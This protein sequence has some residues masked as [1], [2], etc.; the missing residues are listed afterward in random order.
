MNNVVRRFV[1]IAVA[2]AA[3][4]GIAQPASATC[5]TWCTMSRVSAANALDFAFVA[6][7]KYYA[8]VVA[9]SVKLYAS[10]S[11]AV[12]LTVP[13]PAGNSFRGIKVS[14]N[15]KYLFA[16]TAKTVTRIDL[17]AL[18]YVDATPTSF[19]T[20]WDGVPGTIWDPEVPGGIYGIAPVADGSAYFAITN[21]EYYSA[22]HKVAVGTKAVEYEEVSDY[23]GPGSHS[24]FATVLASGKVLQLSV[25]A[26]FE[27]AD[28]V[29]WDV[30]TDA[31]SNCFDVLGYSYTQP[32][33]SQIGYLV[34]D[35]GTRLRAF[36][37][38]NVI[39]NSGCDGAASAIDVNLHYA[40]GSAYVSGS[41]LVKMADGNF[42]TN[43]FNSLVQT[44]VQYLSPI[45]RINSSTGVIT[46]VANTTYV[47]SELARDGLGTVM[48]S[49]GQGGVQGISVGNPIAT[50]TRVAITRT[51]SG[52]FALKWNLV[53]LKPGA[54][55]RDY[56][57][58]F[59]R[60]S[61]NATSTVNDGV[62]ATR[63]ATVRTTVAGKY[64][65][66]AVYTNGSVSAWS[67]AVIAT[68]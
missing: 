67:A 35:S 14:G 63:S 37:P 33:A 64:Q 36:N 51:S 56:Q 24:V 26:S 47:T 38:S 28:S 46:K 1:A 16:H 68:P 2:V 27:Y 52:V 50:P 7:D 11:Q 23:W 48:V 13:A 42:Y 15:G 57:I 10:D 65:V 59:K 8:I 45:V 30:A 41:G 31:D 4:M 19:S 18:T 43:D 20:L 5:V 39:S 22:V 62:S 21:N 61:N 17:T 49:Y 6:D 3:M 54:V 12:K 25:V 34:W 53:N 60:T 58:Q 55:V 32:S 9:G 44:G 29:L 40:T 66:R